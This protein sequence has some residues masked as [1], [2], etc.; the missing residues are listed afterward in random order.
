MCIR[1]RIKVVQKD[2]EKNNTNAEQAIER[3]VFLAKVLKIEGVQ[4]RRE[5]NAG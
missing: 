3:H 2:L 1:D 5:K 4:G